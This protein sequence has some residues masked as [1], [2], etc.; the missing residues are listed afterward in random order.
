MNLQFFP[1]FSDTLI[2]STEQIE[3]LLQELLIALV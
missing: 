3:K 1:Q 2:K